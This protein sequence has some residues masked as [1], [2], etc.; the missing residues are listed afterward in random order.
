MRT[1]VVEEKMFASERPTAAMFATV[2]VGGIGGWLQ[3]AYPTVA[4]YLSHYGVGPVG[5]PYA[6][7]HRL[8]A[9]GF[10]VEAGFEASTPVAGEGDVEPSTLPAGKAASTLHVGPYEELEPA[11]EALADWIRGRGASPSGDPWEIYETDPSQEPDPA[12][13]RTEVFMPFRES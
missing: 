13:W 4:S 7:F 10:E 2:D 3:K 1:Y 11:Y 6:R 8:E 5:P 12:R 9:G